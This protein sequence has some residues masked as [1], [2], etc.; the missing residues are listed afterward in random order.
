MLWNTYRLRA[1]HV[2]YD[3]RTVTIGSS[4]PTGTCTPDTVFDYKSQTNGHLSFMFCNDHIG[5]GLGMGGKCECSDVWS[6][7]ME[8]VR[9][10]PIGRPVPADEATCKSSL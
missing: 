6:R 4:T 10:L 7:S 2:P 3:E 8:T 9:Y 1:L 5:Q